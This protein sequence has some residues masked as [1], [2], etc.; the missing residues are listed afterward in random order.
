MAI[1][2]R[3][4]YSVRILVHMASHSADSVQSKHDIA[5]AEGIPPAY[6][7][8]LMLVLRAAGFVRSRRGREGGFALARDPKTIT[9]SEVLRATEGPIV[10]AP[11]LGSATCTREPTCPTLP[12]WQKAGELLEEVFAAVTIADLAARP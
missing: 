3:G 1:S 8:Q 6:V 10:L 9:V 11:C 7:Q 4:R 2:S 5:A 12:L